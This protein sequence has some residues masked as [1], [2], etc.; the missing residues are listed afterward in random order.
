MIG[1]VVGR[2]GVGHTLGQKYP[3]S[4]LEQEV[5]RY[6]AERFQ[7]ALSWMLAFVVS[8]LPFSAS[9]PPSVRQPSL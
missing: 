7:A 9:I 1:L 4:A 3:G 8:P 2:I 5:G 6:A